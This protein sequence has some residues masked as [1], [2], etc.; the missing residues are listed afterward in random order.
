MAIITPLTDR[1][2]VVT[3]AA[4]QASRFVRLLGGA[5]ATAIVCPTIKIEPLE[6]WSKV[7][8]A[9]NSLRSGNYRWAAFTSANGVENFLSRISGPAS[10]AFG[11]TK[12][13]AVGSATEVLLTAAGL[14]V[15][16][17]PG[18]FTAQAL[19]DA[20]GSGTGRI[21]LPRAEKV[22]PG[23]VETLS[24]NGWT[25]DE[26]A[27]YRTVPAAT[28][29]P[30]AEA[31][32]EARFDAVSFTSASTVEGFAAM[33]PALASETLSPSTTRP[34]YVACIGP[35]TRAACEAAGMRVDVV[36]GE[37]TTDGLLRALASLFP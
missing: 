32:A 2:I 3:R 7:D 6:D 26:V 18:T 1:F 33:F 23:M 9:V 35:V 21:L 25:A 22:P 13:A 27:V 15:E 5:G 24:R 30:E 28:D 4:E 12:V 17:R 8:A 31:V 34:P 29:T 37:H 16:L 10:E 19:A 20:L 36:A 11:D 14:N